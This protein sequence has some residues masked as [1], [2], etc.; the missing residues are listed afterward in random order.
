MTHYSSEFLKKIAQMKR[1][2][3]GF[4]LREYKVAVERGMTVE[5]LRVQG[6]GPV[7]RAERE[8]DELSA[9]FAELQEHAVALQEERDAARAQVAALQDALREVDAWEADL[10]TTDA[11]WDGDLP[12]MT[13]DLYDRWIALQQK[14][15]EALAAT[16]D[17]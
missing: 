7:E 10:L 5:E 13:Q 9:K 14:R 8:R 12:R 17:E 2:A 15:C 4:R 16:E 1:D 6:E 11:A 3:P